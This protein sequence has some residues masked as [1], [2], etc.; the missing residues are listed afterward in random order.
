MNYNFT[1]VRIR[2]YG[3]YVAKLF[4]YYEF[5]NADPAQKP[6]GHQE[7]AYTA[8]WQEHTFR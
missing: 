4:V 2:N 5:A 6:I 7:I 8:V 3:A 1:S